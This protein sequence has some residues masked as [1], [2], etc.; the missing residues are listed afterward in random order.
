[1]RKVFA[2]ALAAMTLIAAGC[3]SAADKKPDTYSDDPK[4]L[5]IVMGSE[6]HLVFEQIVAPWCE[7]NKLVCNAKE[8]GS[9]DQANLLSENCDQLPPY[10]IFWFASTVFEQIGN[11]RCN[12][13]VDSKPMF[14]SPIVFA[15]WQHV[16]DKLEFTPG[17]DT[18]IRQILD[19]VDAGKA[20][21]WITNPTQSN[22]GATAFFGF[23]NYLAGNP[24]GK[25]LTQD[26][27][28]SEPVRSGITRVMSKFDHTPS[29]TKLLMDEC[30]AA[31]DRC[32]AMFT[33]E[34][35][36]I[37]SNRD[38]V[39][40]GQEPMTVVYPQGSLAFADSPLGFLPHGDNSDKQ[41]NFAALQTYLLSP[42]AQQ[43]LLGIGRRP[44]NSSGLAL[45]NLPKDIA[46]TVFRRDWG[47]VTDRQEQ[48]I[49]FPSASVIESALFNYNT[50]YRQP[51]NF[52]YCIDGSGSMKGD[53]WDGVTSAADILF[54]PDTAKKYMLLANPKDSTTVFIFDDGIKGGPWTVDGNKRDDLLGLRTDITDSGP[55]GGTN[56]R[57]CLARAADVFRGYGADSRKKTVV[58]MTD[59][60]DGGHD[61]TAVDELAAMGIPVIAIGFGDVDEQDLRDVIVAK[62]NGTY[63]RKDN[64][65]S[66]LR[67]AAGFR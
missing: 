62:T 47:I 60:Q 5:S 34:A 31:P 29:S 43:A 8:L 24:P 51:G 17:S 25:A 58:L 30:I 19:V 23:L 42:D 1:M 45:P 22:S 55:G 57:G 32:D 9:V 7:K 36:V 33:Y 48:P 41:A 61:D 56:I 10:D 20:K 14:S 3:S 52:V 13:L 46:D 63:I 50:E 21:V 39:A 67:D 44:V 15:G 59:G 66:A 35:L 2:A 16:M 65:V 12:K 4:V 6:Q 40:S 28:D 18:S 26:Q 53:G 49:R 37:E 38:R 64:L 54:D 11:Q 27:L